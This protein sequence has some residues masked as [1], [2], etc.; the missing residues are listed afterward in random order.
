MKVE[1]VSCYVDQDLRV[2]SIAKLKRLSIHSLFPVSSS[3]CCKPL[4][5]YTIMAVSLYASI[6]YLP[7]ILL[8]NAFGKAKVLQVAHP[9]SSRWCL[10]ADPCMLLCT[11]NQRLPLRTDTYLA[12][13]PGLT[14]IVDHMHTLNQWMRC[15]CYYFKQYILCISNYSKHWGGNC[16]W[17]FFFLKEEWWQLMQQMHLVPW[18]AMHQ[19]CSALYYSLINWIVSS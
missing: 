18:Y 9:L 8:F 7:I 19:K 10:N 15:H 2:K 1:S 6:F 4:I 13:S 17:I 16:K 3:P 11:I 14:H 5:H 12:H